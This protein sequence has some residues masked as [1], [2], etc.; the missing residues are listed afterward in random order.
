M[1]G[2]GR[3]PAP[4]SAVLE[5]PSPSSCGVAPMRANACAHSDPASAG[6]A[7]RGRYG[8]SETATES[9]AM[10]SA[11]TLRGAARPAGSAGSALRVRD[12]R[13]LW[14][15]QIASFSGSWMQAVAQGCVILS[16]TRSPLALGLLTVT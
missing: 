7:R 1:Y 6:R 10:S 5:A 12:F 11:Q 15:G 3:A 8:R 13:L 2:Y 16:L 9:A 14:L 4:L